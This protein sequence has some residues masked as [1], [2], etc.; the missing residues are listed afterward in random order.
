[1]QRVISART[2]CGPCPGHPYAQSRSGVD[3]EA[4]RPS[5]VEGRQTA[6]STR[7]SVN[8]TWAFGSCATPGP[9]MR[10]V[11]SLFVLAPWLMSS[12]LVSGAA[13]AASVYAC[14]ASTQSRQDSPV[15][16]SQWRT[17]RR[18]G[19]SAAATTHQESH[20]AFIVI[21]NAER[22]HRDGAR[23]ALEVNAS[24]SAAPVLADARSSG[25]LQAPVPNRRNTPPVAYQCTAGSKV[26]I[27]MKPCPAIYLKDVREAVGD[28]T[29]DSLPERGSSVPLDRIPVRQQQLSAPE[30]CRKLDDHR[31]LLKHHGSSDVYAR[32]VAKSKYC[33]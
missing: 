19:N 8:A 29:Y 28:D 31:I 9:L 10:R 11:I 1:M 4:L 15:H 6:R 5:R 33:P 7:R 30:L 22:T 32:N 13:N 20:P 25:Q 2:L 14:P 24:W 12:G 23:Q 27:Q 17:G 18:P 26:W 16:C 21:Q 3:G